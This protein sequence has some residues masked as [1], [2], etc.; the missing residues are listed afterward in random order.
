MDVFS[1]SDKLAVG[2]VG[3][4]KIRWRSPPDNT[5]VG[6]SLPRDFGTGQKTSEAKSSYVVGSL[7]FLTIRSMQAALSS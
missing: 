3:A 4:R 5:G 1:L 7:W 6:G 2:A